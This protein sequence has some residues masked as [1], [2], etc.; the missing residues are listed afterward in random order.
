MAKKIKTPE[1]KQKTFLKVRR[2]TAWVGIIILA[3][4]YLSTI[5][6]ALIGT[7]TSRTLLKSSI[8][9]TFVLP[10]L[11]YGYILMYRVLNGL[12]KEYNDGKEHDN[13]QEH[14]NDKKN[15]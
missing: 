6:F 8:L 4:L 13:G 3:G 2:I 10:V 7:E 14:D 15:P 1:E 5:I 12:G 11:M 9:S